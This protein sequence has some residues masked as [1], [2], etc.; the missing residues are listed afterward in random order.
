VIAIEGLSRI[1]PDHTHLTELRVE[2]NKV[3]LIGTSADAPSL[4]GLIEKSG[5]FARATFIAPTTKLPSEAGERFHIEAIIE[6]L[7][8]ARS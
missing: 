7:F 4:I 1:L 3:R 6:P 2:G 8:P 5:L